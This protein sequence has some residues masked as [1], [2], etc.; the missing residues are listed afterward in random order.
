MT[1]RSFRRVPHDH[2]LG[3]C[4]RAAALGAMGHACAAWNRGFGSVLGFLLAFEFGDVLPQWRNG[5]F[6][7]GGRIV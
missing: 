2:L 7:F 3:V 6:N 1:E 4:H 5:F